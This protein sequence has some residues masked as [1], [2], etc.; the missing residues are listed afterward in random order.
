MA[1]KCNFIDLFLEISCFHIKNKISNS[2]A[3]SYL[4]S[5]KFIE[6]EKAGNTSE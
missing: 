1:A 5:Q 4:L 2:A 6:D 3:S